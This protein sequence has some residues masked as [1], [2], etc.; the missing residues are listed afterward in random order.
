[1]LTGELRNKINAIWNGF[2]SG[3]LSDPLQV[4][5]QIISKSSMPC[6]LHCNIA[7]RGDLTV[8]RATEAFQELAWSA[9]GSIDG[10]ASVSDFR[11]PERDETDARS[12]L[13]AVV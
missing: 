6:S 7:F 12:A 11:V 5:E 13:S 9:A 1:M 10:S 8:G 4:I 3:G 2:W